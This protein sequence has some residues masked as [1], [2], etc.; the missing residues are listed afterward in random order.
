MSCSS[1]AEPPDLY[2]YLCVVTVAYS[3]A[4]DPSTAPLPEQFF[5]FALDQLTWQS[6]REHLPLD[7]SRYWTIAQVGPWLLQAKAATDNFASLDEWTSIEESPELYAKQSA[8][9]LHHIGLI[10]ELNVYGNLIAHESLWAIILDFSSHN[11]ETQCHEYLLSL[12]KELTHSALM[13]TASSLDR[14]IQDLQHAAHVFTGLEQPYH[15]S[16]NF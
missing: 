13:Q 7:E 16:V 8:G 5:D 12:I 9:N 2:P 10:V 4:T 15:R 14:K 3:C 1:G 6:V 11:E